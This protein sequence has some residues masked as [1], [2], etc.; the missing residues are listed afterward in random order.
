MLSETKRNWYKN[1]PEYNRDYYERMKREVHLKKV[2]CEHCGRVVT[3]C[4]MGKHKRSKKCQNFVN[5]KKESVIDR[6]NKLERMVN[7]MT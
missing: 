2:A 6:L 3:R 1:H 4:A 7:K 5:S